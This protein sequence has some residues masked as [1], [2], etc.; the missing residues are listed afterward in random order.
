[1]I[2]AICLL[3]GE[4]ISNIASGEASPNGG[5]Q[6][7]NVFS[8]YN[9]DHNSYCLVTSVYREFIIYD[10]FEGDFSF[11]F[12]AKRPEAENYAVVSPSNA[13]ALIKKLNPNAGF[14]TVEYISKDVTEISK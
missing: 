10:S 3:S 14:S 4:N 6:Y 7:L 8:N 1:M 5:S 13:K 9:D 11:K 2:P 12:D